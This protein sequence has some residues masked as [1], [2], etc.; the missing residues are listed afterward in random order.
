MGLK[1]VQRMTDMRIN[2]I[3]L[4]DKFLLLFIICVLVPLISTNG[5]LVSN[6]I[7][8]ENTDGKRELENLADRVEYDIATQIS[9]IISVADYFY[10]DI[11]VSDFLEEKYESGAAYYDA[12][13]KLMESNV[14]QNFK[15]AETVENVMICTDN[16]TITNGTFFVKQENVRNS[17]W[18]Q[19]FMQSG[20][21]RLFYAFFED[22]DNSEGYLDGG[23]HI[24][25]IQKLDYFGGDDIMLLDVDYQKLFGTIRMAEQD[26]AVYDAQKTLFSNTEAQAEGTEFAP[27]PVFDDH[28]IFLERTLENYGAQWKVHLSR[29]YYDVRRLMK[30][31][32]TSLLLLYGFNLILPTILMAVMFQS[33]KR[34]M[35]ALNENMVQVREGVYEEISQAG[36]VQLSVQRMPAGTDELGNMIQTYNLM[37]RKIKELIEIDFKNREKQQNLE[38]SRKQAELAALQSQINPHFMFNALE[39]IRMHSI[40]KN[41]TETAKILE[42]FAVLMRKNIQWNKDFVTIAEEMDNVSRYLQIQKYRFG[43]RLT[44]TVNVQKECETFEIPKFIII[45]FVENACVHGIEDSLTGGEVMVFVSEDETYL[46]FE[47][48]D[49][50]SG[51]NEEDLV[52][53][54]AKI[55]YADISDIQKAPKS[56]GIL[57]SVVRMRQYYGSDVVIDVNS[58]KDEGTEICVRIPKK[59]SS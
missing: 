32:T 59:I 41:E 53:L 38:I 44:Y 18:Y 55:E 24:V 25:L 37:I 5:F 56:I 7:A 30:D 54:K 20:R 26:I 50:G 28:D 10:T 27:K 23:R 14:V 29:N 11:R 39:S 3:K 33:F 8:S 19:A 57:N 1:Q 15:S 42:S 4:K 9:N 21:Q 16:D 49:S 40:L 13:L 17:D 2:N 36:D 46:Y 48:M 58:T 22:G 47:I 31:N 52:A 6:M 45:T 51:M 12:Y 34:R 35:Y 43:D